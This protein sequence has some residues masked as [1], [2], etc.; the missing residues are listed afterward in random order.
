[1]ARRRKKARGLGAH[2]AFL[3]ESGFLLIP[4]L[5]KTWAPVGQT[6]ILRHHYKRDKI[7]VISALTVSAR[8]RRMGLYMQF[9]E[10]NLTVQEVIRFLQHLLRHVPGPVI[11]LWDGGS[12][13][14]GP[15][16]QAFLKRHLRLRVERFPGYAPDLNPDEFVW[17]NLDHALSNGRPDHLAGLREN[18]RRSVRRLQQSQRLLRA[19]INASDLPLRL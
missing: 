19:C 6:P 8:R 16:I 3:D 10:K 2:L 4:N 11:L 17:N 12:I 14:N 15:K 1:M 13:H 18:L 5:R 7:S 9:H